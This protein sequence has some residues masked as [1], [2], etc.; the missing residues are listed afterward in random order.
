MQNWLARSAAKTAEIES[1]RRSS[2][3]N[4]TLTWAR[5]FAPLVLLLVAGLFFAG[6][7]FGNQYWTHRFDSIIE[8]QAQIYRLDPL[9]VWS[10]I[11]EE[12]YFQS[13][14]LGDAGEVGLMQITPAV[15]REWARET[16]IEDLEK[17]IAEN[18]VEALR[19]PERNIQIGCWYL[20]KLFERYRDLPEPEAR[21]LAAYNAGPSRVAEWN[22]PNPQ[23]SEDDFVRR[24]DITSTRAYVIEILHRY[25]YLRDKQ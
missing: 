9:L 1:A 2:S 23:S 25:R 10:I 24:I 11:H 17:E 20:E 16:G 21:V 12:T 6:V 7:Y 19:D 5:R 15:A 22:Q 3:S 8:R 14:R 13:S 18:H 4:L